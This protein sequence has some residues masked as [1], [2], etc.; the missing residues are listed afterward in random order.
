MNA[1][2]Y[3]LDIVVKNKN[4]EFL[5]DCQSGEY[6]TFG[7]LHEHACS[8][9]QDI[10]N[11][12]LKKGDRIAVLL[13][14][15]IDTALLYFGC[16]YSGIATV[17]IN[18]VY[19]REEINFFIRHSGVSII[20]VSENTIEK[21]QI[22]SLK[23]NGTKILQLVQN[24]KKQTEEK[25]IDFWNLRNLK[26]VNE[27]FQPF[28]Y[29][30]PD[31]ILTII[32]TSGT[33]AQPKGV[34]HRIG[35]LIDNAKLFVKELDINSTNR[36][37]GILS[38]TYLGGYYNLLL[39]PYVAGA[40]VALSKTFNA[41]SAIDFWKPAITYGVNTL[42]LVPTIISILLKIDR[43]KNGEKFCR[44][45]VKCALVG[46]APLPI[47]LRKD[48]EKRYGVILYE[49]YGLS[50]TLFIST[51]SPKVSRQEDCVGRVLPG[52]QVTIFDNSVKALPYGEEGEIYV[53]TFSLMQGYYNSENRGADSIDNTKWFGTGDIGILTVKGDLSITGRKKDLIIRGGINIS[54]MAIENILHNHPAIEQAVVIGIPHEILGEDIVAVIK[55]KEGNNFNEVIGSIKEYSRERLGTACDIGQFFQIEEFPLGATGKILKR[56]IK[57]IVAQKLELTIAPQ[58]NGLRERRGEIH[59]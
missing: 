28:R 1:V 33:T 30:R 51:N 22:E 10:L 55:L 37:Y 20:V 25:T 53:R 46:T 29:V 47:K 19:S 32:Y 44:E 52:V 34:V 4:R 11:K 27:M 7:K 43:G 17:P 24:D 31:D 39:L 56:K 5:I 38:M 40:S 16:L 58:K 6:L 2:E 3:L 45:K 36:F 12:G 18:P 15:S 59:N 41:Q 21:I 23:S 13:D 8:I 26:K 14:N 49:N 35:S 48:F 9:A 57:E 42:W 50:E 54:P